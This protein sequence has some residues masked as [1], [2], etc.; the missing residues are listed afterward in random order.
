MEELEVE[1]DRVVEEAEAVVPV[2][3]SAIDVGNQGIMRTIAHKVDRIELAT[4]SFCA[5]KPLD[6]LSSKLVAAAEK[7]RSFSSWSCIKARS[8]VHIFGGLSPV[9]EHLIDR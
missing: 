3:M 1:M 4:A 8:W 7:C 2:E 9:P 5:S 6:C